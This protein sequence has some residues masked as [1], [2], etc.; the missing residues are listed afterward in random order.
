MG[1]AASK[2]PTLQRH[3]EYVRERSI[4]YVN[5]PENYLVREGKIFEAK[6]GAAAA[7]LEANDRSKENEVCP[8]MEA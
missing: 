5:D 4:Q 1:L 2:L 3:L 8:K 7:E 6:F